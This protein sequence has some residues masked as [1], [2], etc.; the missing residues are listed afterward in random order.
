MDEMITAAKEKMN[1]TL[2]VLKNEYS[3]IRAGRASPA[4]LERIRV[5]YYGVPTP[6]NQMAQVS[7]S[8]ARILNIQPYDVSTLHPIEKAIQASDLGINPQN[9]GRVIRLVFPPLTEDKR[10]DI[11]RDIKKM[12]EEAKVAVRSIR[13]DTI[14]KLKK[15]EKASEITEDDLK[16]MEK[17]LQKVTDDHIK[18]IDNIA[19]IKEKEVMEI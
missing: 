11:V 4:V 2:S 3:T 6:I 1:K 16:D 15:M 19:E 14:E 17:D 10:R 13:R 8:E 5:D 12:A 7:V 9:D 18:D